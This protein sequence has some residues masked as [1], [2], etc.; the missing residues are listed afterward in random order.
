MTERHPAEDQLVELALD[1]LDRPRRD[2]VLGHL[3]ECQRCRAEYDAIAGAL[4]RVLPAAPRIAPPAGFDGAVV[5]ALRVNA[6]GV[7]AAGVRPAPRRGRRAAWLVAAVLLGV[8]LGSGATVLVTSL[9]TP[10]SDRPAE[11]LFADGAVLRT[12]D[13]RRVGTVAMSALEGRPVV[14][15][16][17]SRAPA[18]ADYLCRLVL[19]DGRRVDAGSWRVEGAYGSTWVVHAPEYGVRGVE[20]VTPGGT[21]WSSARLAAR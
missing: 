17:V 4:D 10:G 3:G 19:A 2:E 7:D 16:G 12:Q 11:V 14:V 20:L 1:E 21:V 8:L 13:G 18:G 9:V 6:R 15:I 5:A